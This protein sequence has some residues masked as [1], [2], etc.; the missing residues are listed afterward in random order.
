MTNT[1]VLTTKDQVS[2]EINRAISLSLENNFPDYVHKFEEDHHECGLSEVSLTNPKDYSL[3]HHLSK[4]GETQQKDQIFTL[5]YWPS[6]DRVFIRSPTFY[7][8]LVRNEGL[9][10]L[11]W[12][13]TIEAIS[14]KNNVECD[15]PASGSY[16]PLWFTIE[17]EDIQKLAD[18]N[19]L[20][21]RVKNYVTNVMTAYQDMQRAPEVLAKLIVSNL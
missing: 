2:L 4:R 7:T 15:F 5:N 14:Q 8:G 18:A 16:D 17:F 3:A 12:G 6:R 21:A 13:N 9:T 11:L 19:I 10:G 20:D 1:G